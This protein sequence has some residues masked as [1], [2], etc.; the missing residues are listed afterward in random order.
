MIIFSIEPELS[1][2]EFVGVLESSG[3]AERRPVEDRPT[4]NRMLQNA[5]CIA[6]ARNQAGALVGVARALSDFSFCTYL[7]DLAVDVAY[8]RQGIGKQ[9]IEKV[10]SVCG[11]STTLIL[12]SAPKAQS[13]YRHIGMQSHDSCWIRKS[14]G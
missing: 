13:Y 6:T 2:D 7:S 12:L 3:L 11:L 8:Q 10:H 5:G 4:M 14:E 9:L 1:T